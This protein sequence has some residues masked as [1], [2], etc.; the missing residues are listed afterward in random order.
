LKI[1]AIEASC[2]SCSVAVLDGDKITSEIFVNNKLTHSQTLMPIIENALNS[3]GLK[4]DDFDYI[5]LSHG[6]GSFTGL[7]IAG[8]TAMGLAFGAGKKIIGVSTLESLC[9]NLPCTPH[10]IS[11]IMD[12][13]KNQV[14]NALYRWED[15]KLKEITPPRALSVEE[16][17]DEINEDVIFVGDGV[18]VYE[19]YFSENLK[20]KARF[21]PPNLRYAKASSVA[22]AA[23]NKV[24]EKPDFDYSIENFK[25]EYIRLSQAEQN[26][27]KGLIL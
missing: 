27:K 1:L 9:Y 7:K 23:K 24:L 22:V 19:A 20:E 2:I 10:L 14:Y 25:L 18:A 11:P 6:P 12:A 5:A 21:A 13:R 4:I 3:A 17:K 16:L 8:A 15:E 26:L